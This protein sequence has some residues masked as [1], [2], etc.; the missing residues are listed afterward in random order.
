MIMTARSNC[1][2]LKKQKQ[3]TKK[4]NTKFHMVQ[5]NNHNNT[6]YIGD[7]CNLLHGEGYR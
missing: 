6:I 1:C 3:K 2:D 5:M 4:H 7:L